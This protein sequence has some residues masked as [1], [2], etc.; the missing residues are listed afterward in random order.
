MT[1]E[2]MKEHAQQDI[3]DRKLEDARDIKIEMDANSRDGMMKQASDKQLAVLWRHFRYYFREFDFMDK[4][5]DEQKSEFL[6]H[7]KVDNISEI[8]SGQASEYITKIPLNQRVSAGYFE[9]RE[10]EED[11]ITRGE[12]NGNA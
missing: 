5:K 2:N 11:W 8:D 4:P 12:E 1:D 9:Q 7:F 3:L 10:V 6:K